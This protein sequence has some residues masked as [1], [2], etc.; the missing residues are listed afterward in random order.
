MSREQKGVDTARFLTTIRRLR[1]GLGLRNHW[2]CG[3]SFSLLR[4]DPLPQ[5]SAGVRFCRVRLRLRRQQRTRCARRADAAEASTRASQT[6]GGR[7]S[8]EDR[9]QGR[10]CP[11]SV[12]RQ[13][14]RERIRLLRARL[15]GVRT[16]RHRAS[17]QL[18][19]ALRRRPSRGANENEAGR[20]GLLLR[21]RACRRLP[22]PRAH[23]ARA[24][25][26][27][28]GR[29]REALPFELREPAGRRPPHRACLTPCQDGWA[30]EPVLTPS[31][32]KSQRSLSGLSGPP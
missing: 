22:R 14:P 4:A 27:T 32:Q 30:S 9:A 2:I 1:T 20:P 19:R 13:L 11:V 5:P 6:D 28:A 17:T 12:G 7:S 10:G 8:S 23:G 18:V 15:L 31:F 25:V 24:A 16:G 26:G 21:T 29:G 3:P